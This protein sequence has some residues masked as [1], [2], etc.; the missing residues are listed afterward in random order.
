MKA[1][2]YGLFI[3]LSSIMF[4]KEMKRKKPVTK[5]NPAPTGALLIATIPEEDNPIVDGATIAAVLS[6][7]VK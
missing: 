4:D 1:L 6:I 5:N 7:V 3:L 2:F